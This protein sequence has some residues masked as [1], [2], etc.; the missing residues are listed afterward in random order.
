MYACLLHT[1]Y[2]Y[3]H[4]WPAAGNDNHWST[5]VW[6]SRWQCDITADAASHIIRRF[7]NALQQ[8]ELHLMSTSIKCHHHTPASLN[9][10]RHIWMQVTYTFIQTSGQYITFK[11]LHISRICQWETTKKHEHVYFKHHDLLMPHIMR[12][13]PCNYSRLWCNVSLIC[14]Q[15]VVQCNMQN[16]LLHTTTVV[17]LWCN[18]YF[19]IANSHCLN[20]QVQWYDY[21]RL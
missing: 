19:I 2:V 18:N 20:L 12:L 4:L 16:S 21:R 1:Y 13:I 11:N 10:D 15:H 3:E 17:L 8:I 14:P 9:Y 6:L 7:H 5:S